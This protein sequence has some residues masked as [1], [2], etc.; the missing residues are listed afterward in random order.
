MA[1]A[2]VVVA[3]TALAG[4]DPDLAGEWV[5]I[6][7]GNKGRKMVLRSDGRGSLHGTDFSWDV[8]RS[9][10][11]RCTEGGETVEL[12]YSID[13]DRL[14][15]VVG[16]KTANF[17]RAEAATAPPPR[18]SDTDNPLVPKEPDFA[19][20]FEGDGVSLS[21][22]K[23]GDRT[24]EGKLRH[25]GKEYPVK[26]TR[27]GSKLSG[28][29]ASGD[30]SFSFAATLSGD[31]LTLTSGGKTYRLEGEASRAANPL[32][33]GP[34]AN[35][36]GAKPGGAAAKKGAPVPLEGVDKGAASRFEHPRGYFSFEMPK[37]WKVWRQT[38]DGLLLNPGLT[39]KDSL[40]AIIVVSYGQLDA[41]DRN[42][43]IAD[44]LTR[45]EPEL[46]QELAGQGIRLGKAAGEVEKVAIGDVPGAVRS[47]AG[48]TAAGQA[49]TVWFGGLV[50][51]EYYLS[52]SAV[53]VK[54]K[55]DRF[56]PKVKR[57]FLT[58]KPRPPQRNLKAEEA[59]VGKRF[60][61]SS[62]GSGGSFHTTYTFRAGGQV[63]KEMLMSGMVGLSD[64]GGDSTEAGRY[65]VIGE[66]LFLY[67][68]GGQSSG[69]LVVEGGA[70]TGIRFGEAVYRAR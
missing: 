8:P 38:E 48:S 6:D 63:E 29:F 42:Q 11:L 15:I 58:M 49:L 5:G 12:S 13:G 35:P 64:V 66:E 55:E 70:I 50:K 67:F 19:R 7:E 30:Q 1:L 14:R 41:E 2:L 45:Y 44:L 22:A 56:L 59:L 24:Y 31:T 51:R 68:K 61:K 26:A 57:I 20:K 27:E 37:G 28:T 65:E 40:D 53:I 23:V 39:E 54:G 10:V 36:L 17:R 47:W 34:A 16:G 60:T 18:P 33:A 69:R 32:G 62:G 52:V 25:G 43:P 46:E 3:S 9:G 21:L 4:T